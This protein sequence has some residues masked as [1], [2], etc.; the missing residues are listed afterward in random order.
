MG[1]PRRRIP[2]GEKERRRH[3]RRKMREARERGDFVEARRCAEQLKRME[4]HRIYRFSPETQPEDD[5]AG[6]IGDG[7][8]PQRPEI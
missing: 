5:G 3:L 6:R 4:A 1:R 7:P 8:S 2:P